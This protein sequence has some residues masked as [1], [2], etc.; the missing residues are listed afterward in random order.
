MSLVNI[1][2]FSKFFGIFSLG[3]LKYWFLKKISREAYGEIDIDILKYDSAETDEEDYENRILIFTTKQNL[4]I[5]ANSETW[6]IDG[7]FKIPKKLFKQML[8]IHGHIGNIFT[9]PLVYILL[10][11]KK[12]ET[13]KKAF[14]EVKNIMENELN[15]PAQSNT[16]RVMTDF[17]LGLVNAAKEEFENCD[18]SGCRFHR[19]QCLYRRLPDY[20]LL[21][22]YQTN[23]LFQEQFKLFSALSFIHPN[24]V[25]KVHE[26]MMRDEITFQKLKDF[27]TNY[28]EP[29]WIKDTTKPNDKPMFE[30]ELWNVHES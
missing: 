3:V 16:R 26:L 20:D 14:K 22:E 13:Y 24:D 12:K 28:Y 7:T 9:M 8:T 11:D 17:E 19:E 15:D 27:N 1:L 21:D 29:I 6:F 18:Q 23:L 25:V 5:L 4:E 2:K 10:P 30:I